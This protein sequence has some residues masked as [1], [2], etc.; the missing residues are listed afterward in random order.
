MTSRD[1]LLCA[2]EGGEPDRVPYCEV[3]VSG[4]VIAGLSGE[5]DDSVFGGIDEMDSR[6]SDT[7]LAVSRL[8]HRDMICF[9]VQPPV[10]A[11]RQI[12]EGGIPF[13]MDGPVKTLSDV[14][15][16]ELPDPDSEEV[17]DGARRVVE[18]ANGR[19]TCLVTRIGISAAYL[20]CG[21]ETFAVALYEDASLIDAVLDLYTDWSAKVVA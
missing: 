5:R 11:E 4:R 13:Y 12:G 6:D 2:L 20:A 16:I 7:E 19:A 15:L 8:L 18:S 17:W 3:G 9:R 10:P 14:D 1:R 21:M